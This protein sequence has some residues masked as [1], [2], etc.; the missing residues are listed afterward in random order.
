[1]LGLLKKSAAIV[2]ALNAAISLATPID[3]GAGIEKRASGFANAVYFTNWGIY[4][5]NFQPADLSSSDI[6]H[7][8]YS[9]MNVQSD[10]TVFSS[11]TYADYEKHY[12][13]DS[14]N[15]VGNNAYGCVKQLYL[16]KKQNR[17][18]K[19]MLSIGGWT[20]SSTFPA[21]A[22]T[23]AT[24]KKFAQTSVA[25]LKDWGFDGIDIDWEY[26]KDATEAQNMVLLLQ[27]IRSELD[28]YAAQYAK[29][30]HFLIS[31]AAPAG[32]EH[33]N[34]LKLA[35]LGKV[36]DY[37]NLMA[38]D[39]AGSWSTASGH[40]AN[41]FASTQ[42]ANSTPYNTNDA[43][44]AYI[45][46]GVPA[47]KIVLGMPI[48]GRSFEQ[49]AGIGKPF[50]GIGS[51][52]WEAGVWDYKALP[53]PGATV[54][55]DNAVQGCYS[56]DSSTKE[57][58]S[59]DTPAVISAKVSWLKSK[60]LGGSMFWEASADKTGSDSLISTSRKG[61]GS[62]DTTQNYLDYPNSQY[63]NIKKGMN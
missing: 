46:G 44:A 1:M 28:S 53:R 4:G 8:L 32:P 61:L 35:D 22:S 10:G 58:I 18:L 17:N 56:Y 16:L 2:L 30:H 12:P 7:V 47:S 59:F 40:D 37:V 43:V 24:R 60:G 21:A 42:N 33:Y 54:Q 45:K 26:P 62:L 38:Y 49:T 13:T 52:S 23:A 27:A 5:R 11:D 39:Y 20:Y 9:F 15:D 63:D 3:S 50:N 34:V 19:L 25:F 14:W 51:G 36:L 57:L 31:I 55:C 29:G 48:Y 6:T 41:L